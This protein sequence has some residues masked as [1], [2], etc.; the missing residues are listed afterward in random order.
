MELSPTKS[1]SSKL[2]DK[3][4]KMCEFSYFV[5]YINHGVTRWLN[6]TEPIVL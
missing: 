5:R 1:N 4:C 3:Y 2:Q 6:L